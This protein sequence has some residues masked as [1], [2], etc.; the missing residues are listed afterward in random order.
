MAK[1]KN[2]SYAKKKPLVCIVIVNWNG[3]EVTKNCIDSLFK[4]TSYPNYKVTLLDNGSNDKSVELFS[5]YK[6]LDLIKLNQNVGYAPAVNIAWKQSIEKYNPDYLCNI[7]NDVIFS[8]KEWLD[9]M[10]DELEKNPINGICGNKLTFPNGEIQ[11]LHTNFDKHQY[12]EDSKTDY[13]FVREVKA[14]SGTSMLIKKSLINKIGALDENFFYGADDTDYCLRTLKSGYKI[15]YCG[16]AVM[17]HLGSFSYNK[18]K[19]DFIYKHQSYCQI[20]SAFRY[21]SFMKRTKMIFIQF[22]RAFVTKKSSIEKKSMNNIDIHWNIFK[23]LA[24]Y[25]GSLKNALKDYRSINQDYFLGKKPEPKN[26]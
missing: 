18:A 15:I 4:Q 21:G 24:I 16:K 9:L 14:I 26:I 11:K 3:L 1:E 6:N 22:L 25:F 7:N 2:F 17:I 23:R 8:Q 5:K 10:I 19:R 20:I 13:G 12:I